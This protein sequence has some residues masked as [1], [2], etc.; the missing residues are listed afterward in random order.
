MSRTS[1][2]S[3]AILE[4]FLRSLQSLSDA[5]LGTWVQDLLEFGY[6]DPECPWPAE[7]DDFV[8]VVWLLRHRSGEVDPFAALKNRIKKKCEDL[9]VFYRPTTHSPKLLFE[10]G[11]LLNHL[12]LRGGA[13]SLSSLMDRGSLDGVCYRGSD[14][15]LLLARAIPR[16]LPD[17]TYIGLW[18]KR[19][20]R[21]DPFDYQETRALLTWARLGTPGEDPDLL[22]CMLEALLSSG[23]SARDRALAPPVCAMGSKNRWEVPDRLADFISSR[24]GALDMAPY[25]LK[26]L[27][28]SC[29]WDAA[30]QLVPVPTRSRP[31]R[32]DLLTMAANAAWK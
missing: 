27:L 16:V 7:D 30:A 17:W 1:E 22:D 23:D 24:V 10:L 9:C 25:R 20:A 12:R 21:Q 31:S 2:D 28:D 29:S 19:L 18:V 15:S 13:M 6:S 8:R 11:M 4:R 3:N 32:S 14:V 26:G 5:D